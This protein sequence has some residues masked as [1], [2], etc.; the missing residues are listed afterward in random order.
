MKCFVVCSEIAAPPNGRKRSNITK[1]LRLAMRRASAIALSLQGLD[2][3]TSQPSGAHSRGVARRVAPHHLCR[4]ARKPTPQRRSHLL[5]G[6]NLRPTSADWGLQRIRGGRPIRL[7][8]GELSIDRLAVH[9]ARAAGSGVEQHS[10][11]DAAS[12]EVRTAYLNYDTQNR[13]IDDCLAE[14]YCVIVASILAWRACPRPDAPSSRVAAFGVCSRA[15]R[16]SF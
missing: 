13:E 6:D 15:A 3:A 1:G 12:R 8:A 4:A 10:P 11:L 14:T 2:L 16:A 7:V 9:R 5:H